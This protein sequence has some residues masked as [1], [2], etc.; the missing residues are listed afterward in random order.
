MILLLWSLDINHDHVFI[1]ASYRLY[2]LVSMHILESRWMDSYVQTY[3]A[4]MQPSPIC[5][6]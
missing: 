6:T 3:S 5:E 1:S 4:Y 2:I